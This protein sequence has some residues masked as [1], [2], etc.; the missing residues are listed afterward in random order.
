MKRYDSLEA[1]LTVASQVLAIGF[2]DGFHRGHQAVLAKAK[3]MA[4]E[5]GASVVVLTFYPHPMTVLF[6]GLRVPLLCSEA[7]KEELLADAGAGS[8]I[9]IRPTQEFLAA[10]AQDFMTKLSKLSG[11]VGIVTG[12]NFS[13]GRGALGHVED[14]RRFFERAGIAVETAGLVLSQDG[15]PISSTCIRQCLQAGKIQEAEELL[16][17]PYRIHGDVVH[18]I[19]RGSKIL[20]FP[21][22]NLALSEDRVIPADGVYATFA[23][24][25]GRKYPAITNVGKNPTFGNRSRTIETFIFNFDDSI[26]GQPFALEWKARIRDEIKFSGADALKEQ[27][28]LD[29]K[30]ARQILCTH[31]SP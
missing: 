10:S 24:V 1:S 15:T 26:Y 14:L 16:G 17:H 7:E 12:E 22:A 13:F 28:A 11:L 21:T 6:P 29:I 4:K 19:A 31:S 27:I 2:F 30:R 3:A 20:G 18:G 5:K 25:L 9:C 8:V 23:I